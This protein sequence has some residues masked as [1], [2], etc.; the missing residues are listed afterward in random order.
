MDDAAGADGAGFTRAGG[1]GGLLLSSTVIAILKLPSTIMTT[2]APTSSER[3]F[4]VTVDGCFGAFGL[5]PVGAAMAGA[6]F[7]LA[8]LAFALPV[9][10]CAA[11]AAWAARRAAAMKLVELAGSGAALEIAL[12]AFSDAAIR[13][14]GEACRA[15]GRVP[16]SSG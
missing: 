16:G 8:G 3:I 13:S 14:E 4:E 2:L 9:V 5:S 6:A 10:A 11:A 1:G 15:L 12:M 7:A